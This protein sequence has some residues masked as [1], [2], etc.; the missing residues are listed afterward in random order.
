VRVLRWVLASV[1]GVV[2]FGLAWW[3]MERYAGQDR[4]TAV[5]IA[6]VAAAVVGAPLA[7]WAGRER[8]TADAGCCASPILRMGAS[9][10]VRPG[11]A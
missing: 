3:A 9:L 5:G 8:G 11:W 4:G 7:W 6:A 2:G 10:T 1:V